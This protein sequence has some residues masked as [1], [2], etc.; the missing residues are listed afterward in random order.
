MKR[1]LKGLA[2]FAMMLVLVI[3]VVGTVFAA[4]SKSGKVEV[5]SDSSFTLGAE[6]GGWTLLT[7]D[8]AAE[9]IGGGVKASELTIEFQRE[10]DA[11]T[12][13]DLTFTVD[14]VKSPQKIY[15][16][17]NDYPDND[18]WALVGGPSDS[19]ATVTFTKLSP[20]AVVVYTPSGTEGGG[21]T[22]PKTGETNALLFIALAA[23]ALGSVTAVV[24]AKKKA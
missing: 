16:F 24:V 21:E 3:G 20:V 10:I 14:G 22:S 7:T 1:M 2:G 19:P 15:V 18:V 9:L 8:K 23:I 5:S 13:I 6:S 11:N 17:H 12:P 4:S